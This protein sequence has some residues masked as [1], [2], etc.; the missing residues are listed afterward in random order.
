MNWRFLSSSLLFCLF[1]FTTVLQGQSHQELVAQ[2]QLL[3]TVS[4]NPA[5]L[6]EVAAQEKQILDWI[7]L[8]V[9][10]DFRERWDASLQLAALGDKVVPYMIPYLADAREDLHRV[11][12]IVAL[13]KV[14]TQAVLPLVQALQTKDFFLQQNIAVVL[15][16]IADPRSLGYLKWLSESNEV[17]AEVAPYALEAIKAIPQG[18]SSGSAKEAF[19]RQALSYYYE[20][21][22]LQPLNPHHLWRNDQGRIRATIVPERLY[23]AALAEECCYKALQLDAENVE[24]WALLVCAYFKQYVQSRNLAK[25]V[26]TAT[27]ISLSDEAKESY[28]QL[29]K[30]YVKKKVLASGTGVRHLMAGLQRAMQKN[31]VEVGVEILDA[32]GEVSDEGDLSS[33][34]PI[35]QALNSPPSNAKIRLCSHRSPYQSYTKL[36]RSKSGYS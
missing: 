30:N 19:Y 23:Y 4:Q 13:K 1:C 26:E 10:G 24:V 5:L 3:L 31:E 17:H 22:V 28:S 6:D 8:A 33:G 25:D 15:K 9:D 29:E 27:E 34:N 14:G 18:A 7:A 12:I 32:L 2:G 16:E 36:F 21:P 11:H 35:F 20:I